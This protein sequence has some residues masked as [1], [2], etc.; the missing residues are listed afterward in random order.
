MALR[1]TG[2]D[3]STRTSPLR[4]AGISVPRV[5]AV[6]KVTGAAEFGVDVSVSGMLHAAV[7]RADRAHAILR[8][9]DATTALRTPGCVAVVTGADLAPLF[10]Y[11]GHIV[12][13]QPILALDK[14]RYYGEPVALAVAEDRHQAVAAAARVVVDYED[15]PAL[16]TVEDSLAAAVPIHPTGRAVSPDRLTLTSDLDRNILHTAEQ[17]WGGDVERALGGSDLV[18]E[19][20]GRYPMLFA[21]G[22][23][24][25]NALARFSGGGLEVVSPC[26]HP[27]MVVKELARIFRMPHS[28]IR[29]RAP[30]I[31]G[32]FGSKAYTKVEPLAAVAAWRTGRPVK[33]T[34]S[35]EECFY[36]NRVDSAEVTMRSGFRAD[37]TIMARDVE[38]ILD[39]GAYA[40]NSP[41][42]LEKAVNRC[43]GPYRVACLRARGRAIYTTTS[44]AASLRALG[45]F[46]TNLAG[47]TNM[48]RAAE[49]LGVDPYEIRRINFVARGEPLLPGC[50][51][52]DADLSEDLAELRAGLRLPQRA[53]RL[54]GIGFGCG[55][56]EGGSY[57]TSS[58]LVRIAS[59]GSAL[60][61]TG[62]TE[63]GQGSRTVLAQVAAE[64]LGLPMDQV[65][66]T[67]GDTAMTP[68]ERTTGGSRTTATA[69]LS[70]QRACHDAKERLRRMGAEVLGVDPDALTAGA[71]TVRWNGGEMPFA[72]VIERWFGSG[73]GGEVIGTGTVRR[74]EMALPLFWEIGMV[75]VAVE[76][77][78]ETGEVD[79]DQLVTVGDV[80]FALNPALVEGQDLGA[81]VQGLGGALTE[82]IVYDGP[83]MRNA[84]LVEYRVPRITDA[85]R[86]HV[87]VIVQ[88]RDG[89]GVYGSKGVGEGARIPVGGAVASAVARAVGRWPDRLPLTPERVWRLLGEGDQGGRVGA[90]WASK[91]P[92]LPASPPGTGSADGRV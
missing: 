34:L 86:R 30:F 75:G 17:S 65:H 71:G 3:P 53:G 70:V 73:G 59:D 37:G 61:A 39:T 1:A 74:A 24:P 72:Q 64:E 52:M 54:G 6:A 47:E 84:N 38:I 35:M 16:M 51:P 49:L 67:Q 9:V 11:F 45:A 7:V 90:L 15:L 22:M 68:Y 81:A 50:R 56:N 2:T 43:F 91:E 21:Y 63:L 83:Q 92:C 76:I 62:S 19:T 28:H 33:L 66:V 25:Y 18:V 55:A 31:G 87:S 36:T 48:D 10:P 46:Q 41:L 80:G 69:G 77:D 78:P 13:D 23:E 8:R 88:R 40:E 58:A 44:P 4:A 29:V 12:A 5:D 42:I 14:V 82:E 26:Q 85:P 89:A 60:V 79:V 57:P 27:F 32:G 20:S